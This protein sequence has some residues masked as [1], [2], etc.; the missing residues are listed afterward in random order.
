MTPTIKVSELVTE[1]KSFQNHN[2]RVV[3]M[4]V[5]STEIFLNKYTDVL[6][7]VKGEFPSVTSLVSHVVQGF[8]SEWQEM[9]QTQVQ[10]KL[11]KNYRQKV[12][13]PIIPDEIM[14]SYLAYLYQED[15]K[16][17]E[18]PISKYIIENELL[19]RVVDDINDLSMT[20]EYDASKASGE[21]GYSLNGLNKILRDGK[22]DQE[23]P[24]YK[25]PLD[26]LTD[27]NIIEEVTKFERSLP[28][29]MKKKLTRIFMSV[30]NAERYD[31]AV[32][33]KYGTHTGFKDK[34]RSTTILGKR[35]IVASPGLADDMIFATT[36]GNM[37]RL[38]DIFDQK[39]KIVDVQTQDYKLKIFMEFTLG[40]DFW[41]NQFVFVGDFEGDVKGLGNAEQMDLLF[42]EKVES[43]GEESA[44]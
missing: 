4:G 21:Y 38:I 34:D 26:T 20:A 9:G 27:T 17:F 28:E 41:V 22:A 8:K 23:Y 3:S 7:K 25:I 2:P 16:P 13:F 6:T 39:P 44:E 35:E 19:P 24:M 10:A 36:Q 30:T 11:L 31:L 5:Y 43:N 12:N 15:K 1:L 37:N 33:N 29:K 40:Y 42:N 18:M 32:F 14:G